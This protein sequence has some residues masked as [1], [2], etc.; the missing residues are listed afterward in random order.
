MRKVI[1][2]VMCMLLAVTVI[3]SG[4]AAW[5]FSNDAAAPTPAANA[6][7][8][9]V[10]VAELNESDA[11]F[12]ITAGG[13]TIWDGAAVQNANLTQLGLLLDQAAIADKADHTKGITVGGAASKDIVFTYTIASEAL[14]G[15][16]TAAQKEAA[17]TYLNSL[18]CDIDATIS[19]TGELGKYVKLLDGGVEAASN[20]ITVDIGNAANKTAATAENLQV[21]WTKTVTI[22]FQYYPV[23]STPAGK[24]AKPQ[25]VAEYNS[26]VA[27]LASGAKVSLNV[28]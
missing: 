22:S 24:L 8:G 1:K 26:M 23:E 25:T 12:T 14:H 19:L 5:S 9:E 7:G 16:A 17:A 20:T 21:V 2:L 13:A 4:Y 10:T 15:S 27:A 18:T 11:T 6:I 3:G 28:A